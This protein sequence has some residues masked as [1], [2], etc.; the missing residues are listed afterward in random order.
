MPR[1]NQIFLHLVS[2][3]HIP[4]HCFSST[5]TAST[6]FGRFTFLNFN[7]FFNFL[8]FFLSHSLRVQQSSGGVLDPSLYA[9]DKCPPAKPL[10]KTAAVSPQTPS[11]CTGRNGHALAQPLWSVNAFWAA[12]T[13]TEIRRE[14]EPFDQLRDTLALYVPSSSVTGFYHSIL[15][16]A[17]PHLVRLTSQLHLTVYT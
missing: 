8:F 9:K 13:R 5:T 10:D 15:S 2:G 17:K 4:P 7:F 3:C 12:R 1:T 14:K 16:T 6:P 11:T